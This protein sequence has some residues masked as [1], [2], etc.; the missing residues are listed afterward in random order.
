MIESAKIE[1]KVTLPAEWQ[2]EAAA[3]TATAAKASP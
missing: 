3:A 2:A 1:F